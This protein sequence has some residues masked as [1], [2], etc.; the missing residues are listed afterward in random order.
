MGKNNDQSLKS[1]ET[2][3]PEVHFDN[4]KKDERDEDKDKECLW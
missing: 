3:Q 4:S 1:I 2:Q